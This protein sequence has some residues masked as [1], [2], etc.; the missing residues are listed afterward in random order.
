[1]SVKLRQTQQF[2]SSCMDDMLACFKPVMKIT[3]LI[4]NPE[5]PEGDFCMTDDDLDEVVAMIMRRKEQA[6][7]R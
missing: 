1:M 3:V 5:N 4:R 7:G 6:N 2:V